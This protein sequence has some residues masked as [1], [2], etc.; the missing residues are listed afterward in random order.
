M[1]AH[2]DELLQTIQAHEDPKIADSGED[3]KDLT[4]NEENTVADLSPEPTGEHVTMCPQENET[5]VKCAEL[6]CMITNSDAYF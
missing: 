5:E 1:I 2:Y 6:R 3:T 4:K